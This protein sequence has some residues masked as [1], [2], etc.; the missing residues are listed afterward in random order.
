MKAILFSTYT[1]KLVHRKT[2]QKAS[3]N[4]KNSKTRLKITYELR[5]FHFSFRHFLTSLIRADYANTVPAFLS[6]TS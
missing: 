5:I 1:I 4:S 6:S 2:K 3:K